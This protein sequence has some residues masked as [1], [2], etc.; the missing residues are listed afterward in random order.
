MCQNLDTGFQDFSVKKSFII[1][2]DVLANIQQLYTS[3]EFR[4][5]LVNFILA[6]LI[7]FSLL[8]NAFNLSVY[9]FQF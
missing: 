4:M 6:K 7:R 8:D 9:I 3:D 1:V 5:T 2:G